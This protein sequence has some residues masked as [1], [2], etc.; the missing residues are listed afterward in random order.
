MYALLVS[1]PEIEFSAQ[2]DGSPEFYDLI[3]SELKEAGMDSGQQIRL[4]K[5]M[6]ETIG[7]DDDELDV[8]KKN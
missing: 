6:R 4:I 3:Y 1:S 2:D 7:L 8:A 5:A